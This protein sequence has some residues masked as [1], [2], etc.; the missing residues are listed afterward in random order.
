MKF[1]II[2]SILLLGIVKNAKLKT[3]NKNRAQY[4]LNLPDSFVKF[5]EDIFSE[6]LSTEDSKSFQNQNK[7]RAYD[8][9]RPIML[10]KNSIILNSKEKRAKEENDS[11]LPLKVL[12]K[13][14]ILEY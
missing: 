2:L 8:L 11:F 12:E 3:K 13:S 6:K 10:E 4:Q 1:F 5:T 7:K 14:H 9:N